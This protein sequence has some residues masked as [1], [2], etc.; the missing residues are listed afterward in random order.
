M[1]QNEGVGV[2]GSW[3]THR[4]Q[5][6]SGKE[7]LRKSRAAPGGHAEI[8]AS[9]PF[10][11]PISFNTATMRLSNFRHEELKF[12]EDYGNTLDYDMWSRAADLMGTTNIREYLGEYRVH[13]NQ[14]SRGP[15]ADHMLQAAWSVQRE[16][17]Q[18]N[19]GVQIDADSD[20][21]HRRITLSPRLLGSESD[22]VEAGTWLRFLVE[23]N[24]TIGAYQERAFERVVS[25]QWVLTLLHVGRVVGVSKAIKLAGATHSIAGLRSKA[26]GGGAHLVLQNQGFYAAQKLIK[27]VL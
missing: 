11:C 2:C 7:W 18:R 3:T 10:F 1:E 24:R 16:A 17:L 26:L 8:R 12:R 6:T 21:I 13:P 23:K 9:M 14:T 4:V 27:G 22:A 19:L 15:A 5:G 20:H 25:R